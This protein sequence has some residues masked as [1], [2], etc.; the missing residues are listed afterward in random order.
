MRV[1]DYAD[2]RVLRISARK[3]KRSHLLTVQTGPRQTGQNGSRKSRDTVPLKAI[4]VYRFSGDVCRRGGR[5]NQSELPDLS[6]RTRDLF[7]RTPLS[8]GMRISNVLTSWM[9]LRRVHYSTRGRYLLTN[10]SPLF[11]FRKI[12]ADQSESII[13]LSEDICRP[14]RVHYSSFGRYLQTIQSPLFLFRKI[15]ADQSETIIPLS[16]DI[17]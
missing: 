14:I 1:H 4:F 15:S 3:W 16:E 17:C 7:H 11:L 12:S 9:L 5:P 6:L 10:Q 2:I 8:P 13:P